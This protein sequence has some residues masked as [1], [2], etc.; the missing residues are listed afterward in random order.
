[1]G[2]REL[3][4]LAQRSE[5]AGF[6]FALISD[7]F[8][9]WTTRQGQ[10]PFV[11]AVIGAIARSTGSLRL[12]T[13]VTCPINRIHPAI[14]AQAAAT[15]ACMMPG[16]FFLGVGT[17]EYLNEHINACHW[18]EPPVRLEMLREAVAIIRQL[19]SGGSQSFRGKHFVVENARIYT[20]PETPTADRR[21][22]RREAR[23]GARRRNRRRT[24][25]DGAG[26]RSRD[27]ARRCGSAAPLWTIDLCV[28]DSEA[29]ARHT[30]YERWPNAALPG[31]LKLELPLPEH[32]EQA[33]SL[34]DEERVATRIV[35][36]PDPER[37]LA[38]IREFVEA[39]F[40]Y[41]SCA[42]GGARPGITLS[43]LQA[44]D[45]S[46][47]SQDVNVCDPLTHHVSTL[48]F[49]VRGAEAERVEADELAL[50]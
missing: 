31:D 6:S 35:C 32:I 24:H 29:A 36:G 34:V 12:G 22:R 33:V 50:A 18:P 25:N 30:A 43:A 37:H 42:P 41:V 27:G 1:M 26:P 9:P 28:A 16:R 11:W 40:D 23:R 15:A 13:G 46:R 44:H 21:R 4:D 2:P 7:H 5:Q 19:W 39:G 49:R 45:H 14:I 3:V 48:S 10:S 38:K 17:G 20:L 8:H 47:S